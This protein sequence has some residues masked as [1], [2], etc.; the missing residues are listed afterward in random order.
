MPSLNSDSHFRLRIET[1]NNLEISLN[2]PFQ[3]RVLSNAHP[4]SNPIGTLLEMWQGRTFRYY[5]TE[6][7]EL[8]PAGRS[9]AF[10]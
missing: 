7:V 10:N 3:K 1:Q 4:L 9:L 5:L 8:T 6:S 2:H